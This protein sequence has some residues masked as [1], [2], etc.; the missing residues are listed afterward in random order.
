M[1]LRELFEPIVYSP[2]LFTKNDV[3]GWFKAYDLDD[4]LTEEQQAVITATGLWSKDKLAK[5]IVNHYYMHEIGF[6]TIGLFI[7]EVEDFMEELMEEYLPLIYSSA[8]QYDPLVNVDYTE[9]FSRTQN[10]IFSVSVDSIKNTY[11]CYFA[12]ALE[13]SY[14]E[15]E[16]GDFFTPDATAYSNFLASKYSEAVYPEATPPSL[17]AIESD[18]IIPSSVDWNYSLTDGS[19]EKAKSFKSTEDILTYRITGAIAFDFSRKPSKCNFEVKRASGDV[20]FSGSPEKLHT[21]TAK[22]GEAV[23]EYTATTYF[24]VAPCDHSAVEGVEEITKNPTCTEAGSKTITY[25]CAYGHTWTETAE[26]PANGHTEGETVPDSATS[27]FVTYCS[28][29]GEAMGSEAATPLGTAYTLKIDGTSYKLTAYDIPIYTVNTN[30][31]GYFNVTETKEVNGTTWGKVGKGWVS[32]DYVEL[33]PLKDENGR[34]IYVVTKTVCT[35]MLNVRS[36]P[37]TTY[38]ICGYYYEGAKVEITEIKTVNEK[39][40]GKTEKGWISM[41]YVE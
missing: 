35:S 11:K 3:E 33:E 28:V 19:V 21:L 26:I 23:T 34:P 12:E 32:L 40:W 6:E 7:H 25:T 22:D 29:C 41:A 38:E 15:N 16:S 4:Y 13:N 24:K 1:Q 27:S 39:A 17:S 8:I 30:K 36:G 5:K 31:T 9:S 37:G 10:L 14:L 20:I 2:S 18:A